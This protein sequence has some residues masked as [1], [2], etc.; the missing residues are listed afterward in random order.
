LNRWELVKQAEALELRS[1]S[2]ETKAQ[3]LASLMESRSLFRDDP[4]RQVGVEGVRERWV[5]LRLLLGG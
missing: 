4:M 5:R 2:M 1:T 3:Q